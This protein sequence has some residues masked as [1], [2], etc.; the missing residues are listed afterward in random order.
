MPPV[1][2]F[3]P[4]GR[5]EPIGPYHH[6]AA[7]PGVIYIGG[8]AGVDPAT[9]TFAGPSVAQQTEQIL[10]NIEHALRAA[11]SDLGHVLHINIFMLDVAEFEEMNRAYVKIMGAHRPARTVIGVAALPAK[12]ALLTMD[13]VAVP[14]GT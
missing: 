5:P 1:K 12:G 4:E 9:K 6:V 2:T 10:R 8:I 13:A 7:A 11:G 3:N 14:A